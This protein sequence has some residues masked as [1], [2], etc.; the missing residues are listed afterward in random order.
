VADEV[1]IKVEGLRELNKALKKLADEAPK[2]LR[3]A[4][5]AAARAIVADALPKVPIRSGRLKG[6]VKALAS[7][8]ASRMKAGSAAVPYAQAVHWGTGPRPGLPGP[9]NIRRNAF[10]WDARQRLLKEVRDEYEK[11]L[12]EL[13]DR[14]AR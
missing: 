8:T 12:E 6:T 13:I 4:N 10:L 14:V 3:E 11:E 9:H 7:T 2:A 5:L 1:T